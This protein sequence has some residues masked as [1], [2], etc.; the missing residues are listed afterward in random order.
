VAKKSAAAAKKK[1]RSVTAN[2]PA[3]VAPATKAV[4]GGSP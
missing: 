3:A 4:A 2:K 1:S